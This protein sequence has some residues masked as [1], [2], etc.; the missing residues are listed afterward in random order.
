MIKTVEH[1]NLWL[2][3]NDNKYIYR[4]YKNDTQLISTLGRDSKYTIADEKNIIVSFAEKILSAIRDEMISLSMLIGIAQHYG[5]PTRYIDFTDSPLIALFF[6]LGEKDS[7]GAF[8]GTFKLCCLNK[9][10]LPP[11]LEKYNTRI[12]DIANMPIEN[13]RDSLN[14]DVIELKPEEN[15]TLQYIKSPIFDE[16]YSKFFEFQTKY[17]YIPYDSTALF[18]ERQIKQCGHFVSVKDPYSPLSG[19]LLEEIVQIEFSES[20]VQKL[21]HILRLNNITKDT[22]FSDTVLGIS[23][24]PIVKDIMS[25]FDT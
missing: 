1:L 12:T 7:N 19:D 16:L 15:L 13:I 21:L 22:L 11:C 24:E 23:V 6:G 20:E 9:K 3:Q 25:V 5:L 4:C 10:K 18:N 8:N 14:K 2:E 17:S